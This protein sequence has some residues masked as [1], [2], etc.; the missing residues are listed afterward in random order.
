MR[1]QENIS[2]FKWGASAERRSRKKRRQRGEQQEH[3]NHGNFQIWGLQFSIVRIYRKHTTI[4]T[5]NN[6]LL[7]K[8]NLS[9]SA[10]RLHMQGYEIFKS[11]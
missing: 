8:L 3:S 10:V 6:K 1:N 5:H 4:P 2:I 7:I 9:Y 11:L